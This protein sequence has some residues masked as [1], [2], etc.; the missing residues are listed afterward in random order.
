MNTATPRAVHCCARIGLVRKT[1]PTNSG[2][3]RREVRGARRRTRQL[4]CARI[5]VARMDL[6]AESCA[7]GR[8]VRGG[9]EEGR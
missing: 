1:L 4:C 9:V 2:A 3:Q 5:G 8:V 7:A 6:L